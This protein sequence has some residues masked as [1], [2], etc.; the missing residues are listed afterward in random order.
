[1]KPNL[2]KIGSKELIQDAFITWLI[3]WAHPNNKQYDANLHQCG[4]DFVRLLIGKKKGLNYEKKITEVEV[5]RQWQNIDICAKIN[6]EIFIIIEDKTFTKEHSKQLETYQKIAQEK[7]Q[8]E[9]TELICIYLKTGSESALSFSEKEKFGYAVVNRNNL[10]DFF[11][12]YTNISNNIFLDFK[13]R[14]NQL[15]K[16]ELSFQEK[17]LSEW[18]SNN[19]IG[20]YRN[21]ENY[22]ENSNWGY[23]NTTSGGFWGFWWDTKR[24]KNYWVKIQIEQGD[25][26]LKLNEVPKSDDR[27][28]I[29][30]Q[31]FE[32]VK[33]QKK[34]SNNPLKI[35]IAKPLRFGVGNNMTVAIVPKSKWLGG[36]NSRITINEL[37]NIIDRMKKYTDFFNECISD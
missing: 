15:E 13:E 24:W 17:S 5:K 36:V 23:I 12:G 9:N 11:T 32:Q 2:F 37:S 6:N 35:D 29:R 8:N 20:F 16:R 25:I 22:I 3:K 31:L 28:K 33:I 26:C 30:N 34:K 1:M 4:Q 18:D 14:I 10:K 21:I 27:S 19:W 7:C